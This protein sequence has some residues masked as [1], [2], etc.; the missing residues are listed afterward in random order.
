MHFPGGESCVSRFVEF[1][2]CSLGIAK[3]VRAF[4]IDCVEMSGLA[5][6]IAAFSFVLELYPHRQLFFYIYLLYTY[7]AN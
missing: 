3:R 2:F 6:S 4:R 7:F 5:S 1:S